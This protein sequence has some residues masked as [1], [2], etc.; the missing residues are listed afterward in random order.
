ML[1]KYFL[2]SIF[3][4]LLN[5]TCLFAQ[6]K[7]S[8]ITFFETSNGTQSPDYF[9]I[10]DWWQKLDKISP[11]ISVKKM[12]PTDSGFP[13]HLVTVSNQ[14]LLSFAQAK[15]SGKTVLL[16]NNGIH[17]GEPDGIDASMLLARDI[18]GGK[19]RLPNNV[20][21]AIIQ[22]YNIGGCLNRGKYYRVDQNGPEQTGSRGN[23]QGLDLNRDF[24]KADTKN[25]MSFAEIFHLTDPEILIDNHVSNGADYQHVMTLLTTQ[26]Q[27]L[28]GAMGE[29]L[30]SDFEPAL[31]SL[32]KKDGFDM[33]PYVNHFGNS[34]E[35]GWTGFWD[36]PRY[37]SGYA[38]LFQCF[39][40]VPETH[41]LKSYAQRVKATY[42]L[43]K[44]FILF[45]EKNG[46]VINKLK[47]DAELE[48]ISGKE[49]PVMFRLD[50]AKVSSIEFKGYRAEYKTSEVS[51]LPRLYYNKNFP[52]TKQIPHYNFYEPVK[53]VAKP[54]A[55]IIPQGWWRVI[56]RLKINK[57]E[58]RQL[59]RDTILQ[60]ETYLIKNFTSSQT[61]YQA[62]HPN[63]N[64]TVDKKMEER[65]FRRGDWLIL[66]NQ[67]ANRFLI[68]TLEP[69][70]EDSYFTWNFFDGIFNGQ[71]WYSAY[72]YEDI[73]AN[74]L[75]K[76]P[77]LKKELEEKRRRDTAFAKNA[78]AQLTFI[79]NQSPYSKT[80]YMRYPVYRAIE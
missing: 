31:Y 16:I 37:A 42:T 64:V 41:M 28:G 32:M 13:L 52:F 24:I 20:V 65:K 75:K 7:S 17:A 56:E 50:S 40:F 3:S 11:K 60:V 15:K 45:A 18:V 44:N 79:F 30:H 57:V 55:Y 29:Y 10:I 73:A 21:L 58:M 61:A 27:K 35:E 46:A 2:L 34:V 53:Y 6:Q 67:K 66:M 49:F 77:E 5:Y 47:R 74:E 48:T 1:K 36:S 78:G 51:G 22:V 39:A 68:E 4:L 72:N 43:M 25:A 76:N 80:D 19:L 12:G 26:Y 70:C 38:A 59:A 14:P 33:V 69:Y 54:K 71:E 9:Q 8:N 23:A 62:H 63:T